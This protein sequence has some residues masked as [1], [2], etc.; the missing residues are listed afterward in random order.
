[1]PKITPPK[2]E[3]QQARAHNLTS[4]VNSMRTQPAVQ[5]Q[6]PAR[7]VTNDFPYQAIPRDKYDDTFATKQRNTQANPYTGT[8]VQFQQRVTPDDVAYQKRKQEVVNNLRYQKWL[9]NNIK[10]EDPVSGKRKRAP[11]PKPRAKPKP[12][13][14]RPKAK[15]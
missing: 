11:K 12:T 4:H 9:V 1:M 2:G 15:K 3:G 13:R 7:G 10:M 6:D 5:I 8:Q 14:A